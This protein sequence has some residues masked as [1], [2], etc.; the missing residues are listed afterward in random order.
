MLGA[1]VD[2]YLQGME[3]QPE[4]IIDT[5]LSYYAEQPKY[6]GQKE[7]LEFKRY[8]KEDKNVKVPPWFNKEIFVKLYRKN[9]GRD[10]DNRHP[11]P[12]VSIQVRY[13]F[14]LKEPVTYSWDKAFRNFHRR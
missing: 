5:I 8:E 14:D 11:Y 10:F 6:K 4:R 9:E 12:Y 1:E 3:E 13:D 7:F 2:F